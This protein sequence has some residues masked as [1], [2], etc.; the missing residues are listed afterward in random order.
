MSG[1]RRR[2][3]LFGIFAGG[4]PE[5]EAAA[6]R[7]PALSIGRIGAYP[8]GS[9]T[10]VDTWGL[11]VDSLPQGIRIRS[12]GER[13]RCFAITSGPAGELLVHRGIPWPPEQVYSVLSGGP[14]R[15]EKI[16]EEDA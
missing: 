12:R 4:G 10:P 7:E 3:F 8:V 2:D 14:V 15:L 1:M 11:E 5:A 16:S 13:G 9:V 6:A